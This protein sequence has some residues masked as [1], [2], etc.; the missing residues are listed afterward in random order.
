M[1]PAIISVND[2]NPQGKGADIR[3]DD[4]FYIR[5]ALLNPPID[6]G[7]QSNDFIWLS[8]KERLPVKEM[9][10]ILLDRW[11]FTGPAHKDNLVNILHGLSGIRQGV[12][13]HLFQ[14]FKEGSANPYQV[15]C[16]QEKPKLILPVQVIHH[17]RLAGRKFPF[18]LLR[19][20]KQK[21]LFRHGHGFIIQSMLSAE[22]F[23]N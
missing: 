12:E 2:S 15:R 22:I 1:V 17:G 11:H 20:F 19:L 8:G 21:V 14:T 16:C 6:T 7:P 23:S 4:I 10:D 3:E 13:Y 18:A 9:S 5:S